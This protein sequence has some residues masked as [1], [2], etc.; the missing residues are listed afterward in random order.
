MVD[1][2]Q[3]QKKLKRFWWRRSL[4]ALSCLIALGGVVPLGLGV[5]DRYQ[6]TQAEAQQREQVQTHSL[7]LKAWLSN[8]DADVHKQIVNIHRRLEGNKIGKDRLQSLLRLLAKDIE[9]PGAKSSALSSVAQ[10]YGQLGELEGLMLQLAEL[11]QDPATLNA[12]QPATLTQAQLQ[13]EII[14]LSTVAGLGLVLLLLLLR[15]R[16]PVDLSGTGQL[17]LVLPEEYVAELTILKQRMQAEQ[18]PGGYIRL[19]LLQETVELL[20]AISIQGR[21][22]NLRL[23]SDDRQIDE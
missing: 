3:K 9:S 10:A 15:Q 4:L 22:D 7:M 14:G 20:W 13:L 23:P 19:R 6:E 16:N 1:Q 2:E 11:L 21:W 17:I 8:V 5:R 12:V 18:C